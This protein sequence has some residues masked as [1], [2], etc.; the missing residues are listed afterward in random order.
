MN[1]RESVSIVAQGFYGNRTVTEI[2]KENVDRFIL[3][4]QDNSIPMSEPVD[5][6][7]IRIPNT[8]D[9]VIVYNKHQEAECLQKR[10][11]WAEEGYEM[12][13]LALIPETGVQ[14][15]SRCIV[16]RMAENGEIESLQRDDYEKFMKYLAD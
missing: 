14:I 1:K 6:S 12:K 16:C 10:E 7:V 15:Y 13:P 9:L 3:G 5:R 8:T 4:Y 2:S 11:K